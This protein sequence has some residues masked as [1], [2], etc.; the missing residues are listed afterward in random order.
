MKKR[1]L[2]VVPYNNGTIGM[3]SRNLYVVMK[4]RED[5]DVKAVVVHWFEDDR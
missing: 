3:C 5:I 1:I 2:I 4:E